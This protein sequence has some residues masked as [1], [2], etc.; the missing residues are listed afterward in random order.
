MVALEGF[1]SYV[2]ADDDAE[3]ERISRLARDVAAQFEMLTGEALELFLDRDSVR[4]GE[5]WREKIDGVLAS[6]AFFV[7]V[8]TPR[9][10]MSPECRRELQSFARKAT[11]LGMKELVL[12]LHYVEVAAL[13]HESPGDDLI[14]L[15][16]RFQWVDWTDLRFADISSEK[17][18]RAVS[19]LA[20]RLVDANRHADKVAVTPES[21]AADVGEEGDDLPGFLDVVASAEKG[22]PRLV[23]TT[24]KLTEDIELIG[25]EMRQ[26]TIEIE[27]SD[28]HASGFSARLAVA[29]KLARKLAPTV[30]R[31]SSLGNEYATQLHEV[32]QG[33][34]AIIERAHEEV[35]KGAASREDVCQFFGTVRALSAAA[36][37]GLASTQGMIDAI[38]PIEK[39]SRD[40][41]PVL[42]RLRQGLTTLVEARKV[43][44]DWIQ[45]IDESGIVCDGFSRRTL[46]LV[47]QANGG[48]GGVPPQVV[49]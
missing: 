47:N 32:D 44:D 27:R 26:A 30:E 40:L 7:P 5:V 10:F 19:N 15:V 4:W 12:P 38:A 16:R 48:A 36:H 22:L 28:H 3:G 35:A 45:L 42:R 17:Y 31:I 29:Q 13:R 23:S 11:S 49:G 43:S 6:V 14:D 2:H 41:R 9:Y 20:E 33:F 1:W 46:D 25:N 18:R 37:A 34:R 21:L 8:L 39:V 24:D